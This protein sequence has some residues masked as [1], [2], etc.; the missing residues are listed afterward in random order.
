MFPV[1]IFIAC[2]F[3]P[4]SPWWLVRKGRTADAVKALDRLSD[5]SMDNTAVATLIEHTVN[6]EKE[7]N[8]GASYADCFKGVDR[9][10]TE[11]ATVV[12]CA[13]SLVGF[14]MQSYSTYFF[15]QA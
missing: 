11:I 8:F 5:G 10:R 14:V 12:W 9:R 13:Q 1:P 4:D 3:C 6:L 15:L 2:Y 7:L